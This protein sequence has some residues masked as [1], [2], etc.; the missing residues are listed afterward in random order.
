MTK[1]YKFSK[2]LIVSNLWS[3]KM[4]RVD[5]NYLQCYQRATTWKNSIKLK[6]IKT[7]HESVSKLAE[8]SPKDR[9]RNSTIYT[10]MSKQTGIDN[11]KPLP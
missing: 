1:Y 2:E 10:F 4:L 8:K 7:S 6:G 5:N 9:T 11:A 3:Q